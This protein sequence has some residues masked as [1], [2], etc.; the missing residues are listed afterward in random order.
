MCKN[1]RFDPDDDLFASAQPN[2]ILQ[3]AI[4]ASIREYSLIAAG[5]IL[6]ME[7]VMLYEQTWS[8]KATVYSPSL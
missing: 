8:G 2:L 4:L 1:Q 3:E 5:V 7:V 6:W